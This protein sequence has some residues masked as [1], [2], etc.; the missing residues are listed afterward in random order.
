[1]STK[2]I[3]EFTPKAKADRI[4]SNITLA[5]VE[6]LGMSKDNIQIPVSDL[7]VEFTESGSGQSIINSTNVNKDVVLKR[8]NNSSEIHWSTNTGSLQATVNNINFSKIQGVVPLS[9][10]GTGNNLSL[11]ASPS[12][13]YNNGSTSSFVEL[14]QSFSI[15]NGILDVTTSSSPLTTKGDLFTRTVNGD[16]RLGVGTNGQWLTADSTQPTGLRWSNLPELNHVRAYIGGNIGNLT[17]VLGV[18]GALTKNDTG[19]IVSLGINQSQLN[20][21]N[22]INGAG[23]ITEL[24]DSGWIS[25]NTMIPSS[26]DKGFFRIENLTREPKFRIL[27]HKIY[28]SGVL[29]LPID[30]S[31]SGQ[32]EDD[33]NNYYINEHNIPI[34]LP[35]YTNTSGLKLLIEKVIP[36]LDFVDN[37]GSPVLILQNNFI[38]S[39][40]FGYRSIELLENGD[41]TP[42]GIFKKI[43]TQIPEIKI[44]MD[45]NED[46]CFELLSTNGWE[47]DFDN[48]PLN[49]QSNAG[50]LKN[51][52]HRLINTNVTNGE[53]PIKFEVKHSAV[54]SPTTNFTG[55]LNDTETRYVYNANIDLND[56][57]KW[58][59]LRI[60]LDGMYA[61]IE[62]NISLSRIQQAINNYNP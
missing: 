42:G 55:P 43:Q 49:T 1:M 53:E 23:Y 45:N 10:G 54:S 21:S 62:N 7:L 24:P 28:F 15:L 52:L 32:I 36:R 60:H 4:N 47:L 33:F 46:I 3:S 25:L 20:T 12:L 9:Q 2:K 8:F 41:P 5:G 39:N 22:F 61:I 14:G 26:I 16:D 17:N 11:P 44:F 19:G 30:N 56:C 31:N 38:Y 51:S 40:K 13:F 35:N 57:R 6:D 34:G 59:G 37:N 48:E 50:D 58:G 18:T 29:T 27:G